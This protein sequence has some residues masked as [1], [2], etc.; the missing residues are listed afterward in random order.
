MNVTTGLISGLGVLAI[1]FTSVASAVTVT[2]NFDTAPANWIGVN[3][4]SSGNN[5][6]WSN[7]NNAGGTA[8]EAGGLFDR[9]GL[10]AYYADT[11][12][13]G[14]F[15]GTMDFAFSGRIEIQN[16][17]ANSTVRVG[18]FDTS[19][20]T[21]PTFLGISISEPSGGSGGT[22]FRVFAGGRRDVGTEQGG[23]ILFNTGSP[24]PRI[25]DGRE[26]LFS[27]TKT[28]TALSVV[29]TDTTDSSTSTSSVTLSGT[30][31]GMDAF[32]IMQPVE[33]DAA[34]QLRVFIDNLEYTVV[35]E[36]ASLGLLSL[37][38]LLALRRR[39]A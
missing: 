16:I 23:G 36:P 20:G 38:G 24:P 6:G 9:N 1:G 3:N 19:A 12:L 10:F 25:V 8:G 11:S 14:D 22:G 15:N 27:V 28:G 30:Y 5:F 29:F 18:Y 4:T 7:T 13:G 26:Y 2:Q 35:P 31:T 17:N 21:N 37:G 33:S 34:A 39:R 32:G